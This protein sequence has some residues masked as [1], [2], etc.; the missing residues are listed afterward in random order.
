MYDVNWEEL[1]KKNIKPPVD[2]FYNK[3]ENEILINN[4]KGDLDKGKN[5]NN[6]DNNMNVN[7]GLDDNKVKNFTFVRP[8]SLYDNKN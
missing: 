2:L 3:L 5:K 7:N 4:N 6:N 1:E 8:N